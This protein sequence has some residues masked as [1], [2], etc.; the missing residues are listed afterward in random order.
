MAAGTNLD[1]GGFLKVILGGQDL[2]SG[3]APSLLA[4]IATAITLPYTL[5]MIPHAKH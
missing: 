5:M 4:L 3:M 2:I 1:L